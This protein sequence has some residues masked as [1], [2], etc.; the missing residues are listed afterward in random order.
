MLDLVELGYSVSRSK[1]LRGCHEHLLHSIRMLQSRVAQ[2]SVTHWYGM[3][4]DCCTAPQTE[5]DEIETLLHHATSHY[6]MGMLVVY[7]R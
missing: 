7:R 1:T 4:T 2:C 3:I 6:A 5:L